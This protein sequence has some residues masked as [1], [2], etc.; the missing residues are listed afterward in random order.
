MNL[1]SSYIE[2]VTA[3]GTLADG[4]RAMNSALNS[5][6]TNSRVR[7]WE[8]GERAPTPLVIFYMLSTVL[9]VILKK[10][11]VSAASI[12]RAVQYCS[13]PKTKK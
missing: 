2:V 3:N 12:K 5:N 6:Y 11:G 4:I 8:R 7:E 1:V 13:L 9:P 10:E